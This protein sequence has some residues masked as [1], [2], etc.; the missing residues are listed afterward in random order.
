MNRQLR[1]GQTVMGGLPIY[2]AAFSVFAILMFPVFSLIRA[3][4]M[5]RVD[6]YT[7]PFRWLPLSSVT[8]QNFITV[9]EPGHPVPVVEAIFNTFIVSIVTALLNVLL[10]SIAAY[11]FCR[12]TFRFKH[13][14][15]S[16]LMIIYLLPGMLFLI[17]MFMMMRA[18]N[19]WDTY[20]SLIIP[21]TA[22]NLPFMILLC[23]SFFEAVPIDIEEAAR[24]DGCSRLQVLRFIVIPMMAPT[25]VAAGGTAFVLSWGE[26]LTP[27]ILTSKLKVISTVLGMY[28]TSFE[29]EIGQMAA[30]A[31]L[32]VL[33]VVVLTLLLQKQIVSGITAGAVKGGG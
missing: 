28:S 14:I 20:L 1:Q 22:W 18:L 12:L 16:S 2:I 5:T 10:A 29:T 17:P 25:L 6:I 33:P 3:S 13:I 15:Q 4:L 11:A 9:L 7:R 19:L 23:R 24:V 27:L 31:V 26:F 32:S 8:L 21:Y 30:A